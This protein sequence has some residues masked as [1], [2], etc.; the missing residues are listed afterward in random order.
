[1]SDEA[2]KS[3]ASVV[4]SYPY[5]VHNDCNC[6]RDQIEKCLR[7]LNYKI[8]VLDDDPTG[9]QT[10]HSVPVFT[11]FTEQAI[12]QAFLEASQ[13]VFFLT[14]SRALGEEETE[15]LHK[16]I[17]NVIEKVS[18]IHQ[19]PYILISRSDSTL[20]GHYPLELNTLY[21]VNP[22]Y[23]GEIIIPSFFE[24]GRY[25]YQDVHYLKDGDDLIPVHQ[26]EFAKDKT[27]GFSSGHL[28]T[29]IMEKSNGKVQQDDI[30]SISVEDLRTRDIALM[31]DKIKKHEGYASIV[32]N[33]LNEHDLQVFSIVILELIKE[34]YHY[35]FRTAA[36]FV[37]AIA[38][39]STQPFITPE[40]KQ[41]KGLII[42]GSHVDLTTRQLA[43]L[44]EHAGDISFIEFDVNQ[45][46]DQSN[47]EVEIQR[48]QSL[49]NNSEQT[50]CLETSRRYIASKK[51]EM[52]DLTFSTK[53]SACLVQL[54]QGLTFTPSFI[55]SK[56]GITSSDIAVHG[57][58]IKKGTVLG[59]I[60]KGISVWKAD[61]DSKFPSAPLI[62]FPGNV[63]NE[64]T[65]H[66][67]YTTLTQ[68]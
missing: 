14:N 31:K 6:I 3:Y 62:I 9:T 50:V 38:G 2:I 60:E 24:G 44:Q 56:G 5:E 49:I 57:L 40:I 45:V 54:V 59:Q 12:N 27:F 67:V 29:Y 65:L 30:I 64:N 61:Q 36:S 55:L 37:K 16:D 42:V 63:G 43:F 18:T 33:A 35:L 19:Q 15:Q 11:S 22:I 51:D 13:T 20:R 32:V 26:T 17:G 25:T 23:D 58:N 7:E 53:V 46:N 4:N 21:E 68:Q 52:D 41:A 39:I 1:M 48:V 47:T 34:G 28:P 66:Q 8:I 10:I